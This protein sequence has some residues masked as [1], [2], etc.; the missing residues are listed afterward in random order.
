M[1]I[2]LI[3]DTFPPLRTSGAVQLRDLSREFARQGHALTVLLPSHDQNVPWSLEEFDGVQVLRLKAPRTKD[4]GYV[5]RTLGEFAMPFAMLRQFRKSPLSGELWD[6]VVWYAPSIFHGP[7][8]SALKRF[9][10][11]KGY[12]IIRDIFPEWAVDMGLMGR[13]LPYRFFDAVA[14]YQY[15]VADVIGVQTP[16]NRGYF[17]RWRQ[18]PGRRLEVLQNWLDK[19]AKVR[20]SIRV[21]ESALAGRKVFVYAGNMGFAQGMD[22]LLDLAERLQ[23]RTDVGFLFVGRGSD[24]SRLKASAKDRKLVNVLFYDEIHP[25]EIP[26]L[27]AQCSAGIVALDPRHKSHNIPGKFLTYMQSG[28]PVLA[29]VNAGNDLAQMI[30]DEQVGQV[31]ESNQV[32]EL[33]QLTDKL[34][35]QIDTQADD[36]PNRC[37]SLFEREFAVDRTVRQIVAA[38]MA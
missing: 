24:A 3:A 6:G 1:R 38:L 12:L 2:A 5:R 20:C 35:T 33:L 31:C 11:C 21:N 32:G 17:E 25:D 26:D 14:R 15:S 4:I 8:A 7:L 28:L 10:N 13:G 37:R 27:Y 23:H 36:L 18:Q 29:N 16:G 30:R 34:L 9:S 22:I 19:P